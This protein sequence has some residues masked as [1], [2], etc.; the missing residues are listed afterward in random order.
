VNA[1]ELIKRLALEPHPEGGW[2]RRTWRAPSVDG[3]RP[4]GSAIYYLL[5]DTDVSRR[6]RVDAAEIWHHYRGAPLELRI[7][8]P[9]SPASVRLLG[10]DFEQGQDP[11]IL[12]PAGRWQQARSLGA[13]SLVGC[14]VSPAFEFDGFELAEPVDGA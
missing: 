1:S 7:G 9:G 4:S 14:T 3:R 10:P 12:V 6:H 5:T 13:Y 8:G 2:Y 11:Q